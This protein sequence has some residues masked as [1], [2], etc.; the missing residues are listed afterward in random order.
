MSKK[1]VKILFTLPFTILTL[2]VQSQAV[3]DRK[4]FSNETYKVQYPSDWRI[5]TSKR[6]GTDVVISSPKENDDDKFVEN[7]NVIVQNLNGQ[8]IDLDKY[9]H[10]SEEQI[11]TLATD[12]KIYESQK[13]TRGEIEHYKIIFTMTQ[14]IFKLRIEQYY[15]M[16]N[17]KAFVITFSAESDKFDKFQVVGEEILNSFILTK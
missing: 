4:E 15:F 16:K 10:A 11:K 12:G 2:S 3:T 14:G 6:M 7:V 1:A 8:S 9:S 17:D 5:D 13:I